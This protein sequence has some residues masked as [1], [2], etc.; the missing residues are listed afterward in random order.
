MKRKI[1]EIDETKCNGCGLCAKGCPEGALRVINGKARLVG[2]LLCDGLGAC[3]DVC[4]EGAMRIVE[5][6]AE[7]YD[8]FKVMD[9]V[10]SQGKDVIAAHLHHLK[11]HTSRI[12]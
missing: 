2:E 6:E 11:S 10:V 8:E 9:N 7:K 12:F 5:R 3:I 4:P 1:I